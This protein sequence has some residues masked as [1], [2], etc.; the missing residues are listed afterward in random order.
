MHLILAAV[1][2]VDGEA[3]K[4]ARQVIG[5]PRVYVPVG[6][7]DVGARVG[8]VA[9]ALALIFRLERMVEAVAAVQRIMAKLAADLALEVAA[10]VAT[11]AYAAATIAAVA[12]ALSTLVAT[13]V[14]TTSSAAIRVACDDV[15]RRVDRAD[16]GLLLEAEFGAEEER[17]E[18]A[19]AD[20]VVARRDRRD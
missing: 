14:A 8:A 1:E 2:L 9:G 19:E 3:I 6:V 10:A 13:L 18:A 16:G 12:A 17:V 7:D 20:G 15:R 11:T 5:R 4:I